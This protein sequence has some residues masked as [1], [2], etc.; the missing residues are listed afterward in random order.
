LRFTSGRTADFRNRETAFVWQFHYLLPEFMA[1]E[2]VAVPLYE[3]SSKG[4]CLPMS[5]RA[6]STAR[7]AEA[8]F[9]LIA[10]LHREHQLTSLIATNNSPFAE[11]CDRVFRLQ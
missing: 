9:S 10:R 6:I 11:R 4:C 1:A 3:G 8:G 7:R 2:N 5:L